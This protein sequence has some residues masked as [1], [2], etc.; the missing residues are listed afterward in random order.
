MAQPLIPAKAAKDLTVGTMIRIADPA[1]DARIKA[2]EH[3]PNSSIERGIRGGDP[4]PAILIRFEYMTG[5]KRGQ[6][7]D[8][9]A[10]PEDR[11]RLA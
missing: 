10:H 7:D 6:R 8:A 1:S 4:Q 9:M 3:L 11:V 5:P 2:I